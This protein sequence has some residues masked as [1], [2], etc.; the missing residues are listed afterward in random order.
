M[1]KY[2]D[3]RLME[4]DKL[5]ALAVTAPHVSPIVR[6]A[7]DATK[8]ED[9][10]ISAPP[11]DHRD[12]KLAMLAAAACSALRDYLTFDPKGR[13]T[14]RLGAAAAL[15]H[16]QVYALGKGLLCRMKINF[17]E[18]PDTMMNDFREIARPS[19]CS[20]RGCGGIAADVAR[21]NGFLTAQAKPL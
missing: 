15:D 9:V 3:P 2:N 19:C 21:G 5:A 11:P 6:Q 16:E 4:A 20:R 12:P 18:Q 10:A 17:V 7:G 1:R 14:I 8:G 13:T